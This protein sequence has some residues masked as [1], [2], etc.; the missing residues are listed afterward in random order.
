ML[1][2]QHMRSHRKH[3]ARAGIQE[4]PIDVWDEASSLGGK[5]ND[6]MDG[7]PDKGTAIS[8]CDHKSPRQQVVPFVG[9]LGKPMPRA[10]PAEAFYVA[11]HA[12][13]YKDPLG[14]E[15]V[16]NFGLT[17]EPPF[18]APVLEPKKNTVGC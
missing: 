17:T 8:R 7:S 5:K 16:T 3:R 10:A 4:Q 13:R 14:Y 15:G 9:S 1:T 2:Y 11:P 12:A 18:V 6:S